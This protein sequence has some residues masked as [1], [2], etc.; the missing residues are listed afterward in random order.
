[1]A[2]ERTPKRKRGI[3]RFEESGEDLALLAAIRHSMRH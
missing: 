3:M 2:P 1:M